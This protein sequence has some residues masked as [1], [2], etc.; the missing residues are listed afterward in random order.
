MRYI[1][2]LRRKI[3]NL[4]EEA[5]ELSQRLNMLLADNE[6]NANEN[7]QLRDFL[8]EVDQRVQLQDALN[9]SLEE[10]I[11]ELR[12]LTEEEPE[13]QSFDLVD[14]QPSTSQAACLPGSED[15]D[16]EKPKAK[17]PEEARKPEGKGK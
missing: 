3:R 4:E 7:N 16:D 6:V 17:K 2:N 15:E 12:Q 11:R 5:A 13:R 9:A 8:Q 14:S 1:T 10:E